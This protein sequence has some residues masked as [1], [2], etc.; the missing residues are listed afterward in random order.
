MSRAAVRAIHADQ[1][2][3]HGGSLGLRDAGLLESALERPRHRRHYEPTSDLMRLAAA[4][5]YGLARNHAFIDGNKRV[6]FQVMYVFLG[7]NGYR[8][9]APEPEVVAIMLSVADGRTDEQALADWI[10][11][12]AQAR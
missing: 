3:E 1:I 7:L 4:Y 6:A 10:R 12:H 5:G 11:A 8:I 9:S 2:R